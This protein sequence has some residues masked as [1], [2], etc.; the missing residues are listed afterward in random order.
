MSS[1]TVAVLATL[2]TKGE[3]AAY[4]KK[5]IES[6]GGQALLIDIGLVGE[7][8]TAPD[9]DRAEVIAKGGSSL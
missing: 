9:I 4:V 6:L 1:P 3:E 5:R 2:D 7:P 8:G